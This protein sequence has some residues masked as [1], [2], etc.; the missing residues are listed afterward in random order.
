MGAYFSRISNGCVT[1]DVATSTAA[2]T[3][4]RVLRAGRPRGFV[5]T[6]RADG[7]VEETNLNTGEG[8]REQGVFEK[9]KSTWRDG[10]LEAR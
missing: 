6:E 9:D 4:E 1:P 5:R 7:L 8:V 2:W 3:E 10:L